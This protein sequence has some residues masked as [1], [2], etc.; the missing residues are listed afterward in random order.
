MSVDK[1]T[2][3]TWARDTCVT[4][5][6]FKAFWHPILCCQLFL[7]LNSHTIHTCVHTLQSF[8]GEGEPSQRLHKESQEVF[9]GSRL[10]YLDLQVSVCLPTPPSTLL[11]HSPPHP[12]PNL[13]ELGKYG[14]L[15]YNALFMI[16]PTL[17]LAQVTGDVEKVRDCCF[18]WTSKRWARRS[19]PYKQG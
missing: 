5:G 3:E 17:L 4:C 19:T 2:T 8:A 18:A 13:Q 1:I 16:L 7:P 11:A 14:L 10:K 15:Y 12:L 9:Y 6:L